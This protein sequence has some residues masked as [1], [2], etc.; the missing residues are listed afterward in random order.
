M[1]IGTNSELQRETLAEN[2]KNES[3][4]TRHLGKSK[5]LWQRK[6]SA[7]PQFT[8]LCLS[9]VSLELKQ[10]VYAVHSTAMTSSHI[11]ISCPCTDVSRSIDGSTDMQ[12]GEE[13]QERTFD[14]RSPRANFSLYPLEHLLYCEDCQQI[15]CPRCIT[16]EV[17]CWYCPSCLFEMPLSLVKS[18]GPR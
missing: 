16:E 4:A 15:R 3:W 13:E 6:R 1:I 10:L 9:S 7:Q 8:W 5:T 12:D 18:E 14:P 17:V 11:Q 2:S